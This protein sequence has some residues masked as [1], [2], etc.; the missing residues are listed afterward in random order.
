MLGL[1]LLTRDSR[2]LR[3]RLV[4]R[5]DRSVLSPAAPRGSPR[6]RIHVERFNRGL[7][8]NERLG[9]RL[10]EDRGVYLFLEWKG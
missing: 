10:V 9:F 4:S 1:P 6:L 5:L 8:L 7:R 3:S 2:I